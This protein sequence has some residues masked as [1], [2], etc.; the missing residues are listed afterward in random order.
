VLAKKRNEAAVSTVWS[1][2]TKFK[3]TI[4]KRVG[5]LDAEIQVTILGSVSQQK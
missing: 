2:W 1:T 3:E 4:S 5:N